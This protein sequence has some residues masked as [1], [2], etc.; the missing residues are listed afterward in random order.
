[1]EVRQIVRIAR[2]RVGIVERVE[3]SGYKPEYDRVRVE[4][5]DGFALS[6]SGADWFV[7]RQL[8]Q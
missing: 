8:D 1:M 4:P 7:R 3:P 5:L 2:G 6:P